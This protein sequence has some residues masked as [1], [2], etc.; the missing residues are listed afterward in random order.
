MKSSVACSNI[1]LLKQ[2]GCNG[3]D[4]TMWTSE[5]QGKIGFDILKDHCGY[6]QRLVE[7]FLKSYWSNSVGNN[8][9]TIQSK[10]CDERSN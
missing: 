4:K 2:T 5:G 10:G 3:K 8:G 7:D 6:F 1:K 9:K